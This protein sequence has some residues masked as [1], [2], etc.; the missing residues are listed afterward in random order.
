MNFKTLASVS[1]N[2]FSGQRIIFLGASGIAAL[3]IT[4]YHVDIKQST[5]DVMYL[6]IINFFTLYGTEGLVPLPPGRGRTW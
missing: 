6:F 2:Y 5:N 4:V 1:G 3:T